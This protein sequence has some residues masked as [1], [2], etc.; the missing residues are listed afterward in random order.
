MAN[1]NGDPQRGP[2]TGTPNGDPQ[3]GPPTGF[4]QVFFF[5]LTNLGFFDAFWVPGIFDP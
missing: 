1:P 4:P 2:P 3:R 5:D